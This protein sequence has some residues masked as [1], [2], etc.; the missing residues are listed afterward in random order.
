DAA[1]QAGPAL[2]HAETQKLIKP[3]RPAPPRHDASQALFAG[4]EPAKRRPD[5]G[6]AWCWRGDVGRAIGA[7]M[8]AP[9]DDEGR[10]SKLGEDVQISLSFS[11]ALRASNA[12][13]HH[14][15]FHLFQA[16]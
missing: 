2:L 9:D 16:N 4:D 11:V 7:V 14:R 13:H 12:S 5:R 10:R 8:H 3:R 1:E 6:G 15:P